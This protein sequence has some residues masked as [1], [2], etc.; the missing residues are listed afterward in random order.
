MAI[1]VNGLVFV[2]LYGA[3]DLS[4][5]ILFHFC[6]KLKAQLLQYVALKCAKLVPFCSS[7]LNP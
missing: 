6:Q 3:L 1:H 4:L 2:K 7:A 5:L